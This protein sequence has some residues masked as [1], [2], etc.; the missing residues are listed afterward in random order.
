MHARLFSSAVLG[1]DAYRVAVEVD[2]GGG[3]PE[4]VTVGL[5]EGAVRESKTRVR[6][7]LEH[8]GEPIPVGRVTINLAPADIRKDGS[9]FDLPIA[10][11]IVAAQGRLARQAESW[12]DA[13]FIGE[14]A[15]DG[16]LRPVR[17]VLPIA[18][19]ARQAGL[20]AIVL[21]EQNA[22]EAAV[23]EGVKV[24]PARSLREVL[25]VL[26]GHQGEPRYLC[27]P[28]HPHNSDEA[29][30]AE[31]RGQAHAKRALEI[32]AAGGHNA[33]L[34]GPP[35]SGKSLLAK[36]L[37]SILPPMSLDE[38][39]ETTKI[40]SVTGLLAPGQGL[41]RER[42]FRAPH[43]TISD[44]GLIGGGSV[45]RPGE[46]SLAHNGVLFLDELPEFKRGVLEVLRQPLEERRV[47]ISRALLAVSF[48]ASTTLVAAMNPCPCG[49][50]GDSSRVCRCTA[51]EVARYR[52]R[53]SGPLL[54]RIDLHVEV[55]P[56]PYRAL[57]DPA[58]QESSGEIRARVLGA[59]ARQRARFGSSKTRCNAEM[60]PKELRR[61][62][63]VPPAGA[64]LLE[65]VVNQLGFSARAHD[66]LLRVART[67]ADLAGQELIA[68]EHLA[69]A[70][71]YRSLDRKD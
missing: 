29:D 2:L 63:Q 48:P 31:V 32:A 3:L 10:L 27:A 52:G 22:A 8:I 66:R 26:R 64:A 46:L 40:Y 7:A 4:F 44:V 17:G 13:L 55:P 9:A 12:A 36:R 33:L 38:A 51:H 11:G 65:R 58:P 28:E 45:P 68:P 24:I 69:E 23:V 15:L 47:T 54:D 50:L 70:V 60:N 16:E 19:A 5:P 37:P 25:G 57:H 56:V 41:V 67:I 49:Y 20:R 61:C 30:F 71:Q 59:R 39:L 35:G 14:L 1:V 34:F 6:S 21:P 42:P 62:C 18:V 53:I 43:H